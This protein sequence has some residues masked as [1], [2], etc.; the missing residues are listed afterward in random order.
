M[1]ISA[2]A[3]RPRADRGGVAGS[4]VDVSVAVAFAA[5]GVAPLVERAYHFAKEA[6]MD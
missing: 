1:S 3:D 5:E 2:L 4:D 6:G